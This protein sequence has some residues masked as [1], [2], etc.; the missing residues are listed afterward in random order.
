MTR[1]SD[2]LVECCMR[3]EIPPLPVLADYFGDIYN[4]DDKVNIVFGVYVGLVKYKNVGSDLLHN[5]FLSNR[6]NELM[7]QKFKYSKSGYFQKFNDL[8]IDLTTNTCL[9]PIKQCKYLPIYD[10]NFCP[11]CL[12]EGYYLEKKAVGIDC[13]KCLYMMCTSCY[14]SDSFVC[15]DS[16]VCK[17]CYK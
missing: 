7:Q 12:T 17:K 10:D 1:T 5:C 16:F 3:D 15:A 13:E 4:D 9:S 6:L 8:D 14:K 2:I 11:L